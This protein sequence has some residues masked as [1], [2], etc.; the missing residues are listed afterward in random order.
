MIDSRSELQEIHF[1]N[2]VNLFLPLQRGEKRKERAVIVSR[3]MT[4][5]TEDECSVLLWASRN[6]LG[7]MHVFFIPLQHRVCTLMINVDIN[8]NNNSIKTTVIRGLRCEVDRYVSRAR[9]PIVYTAYNIDVDRTIYDGKSFVIDTRFDVSIM[10]QN[11]SYFKSM[12]YKTYTHDCERVISVIRWASTS[13]D[14]QFVLLLD[15]MRKIFLH[16][17]AN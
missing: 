4:Y 13:K 12:Y 16:L 2:R 1:E 15:K 5:T 3:F 17:Y 11:K 7:G 6:S 10:K 9:V 8:W 14:A